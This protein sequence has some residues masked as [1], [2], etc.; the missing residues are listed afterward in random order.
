M[1]DG[2]PREKKLTPR[3]IDSPKEQPDTKE[4]YSE[5]IDIYYFD[6]GNSA[7]V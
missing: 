4:E 1:S 5:R 6:H 3:K 2:I 7:Y